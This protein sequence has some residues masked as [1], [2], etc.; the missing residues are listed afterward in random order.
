MA[1][2]CLSIDGGIGKLTDP[3]FPAGSYIAARVSS[4][5]YDCLVEIAFCARRLKP[6]E[7]LKRLEPIRFSTI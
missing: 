7:P 4:Q 2:F 5:S 3:F 6:L 1:E